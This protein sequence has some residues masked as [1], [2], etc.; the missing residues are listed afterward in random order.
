MGSTA[1]ASQKMKMK[2]PDGYGKGC[3]RSGR[4]MVILLKRLVSSF[5]AINVFALNR[6]FR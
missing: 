1:I 3:I 6:R 5:E 4:S 2:K